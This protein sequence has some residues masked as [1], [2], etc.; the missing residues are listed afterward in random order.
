L[1]V[2]EI[3]RGWSVELPTPS[4]E[5]RLEGCSGAASQGMRVHDCMFHYVCN[6]CT[7]SFVRRVSKGYS[8]YKDMRC[9]KC[10]NKFTRSNKYFEIVEL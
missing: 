1:E 9:K 8:L 6:S 2:L 5:L 10:K 4:C 7:H 3:T